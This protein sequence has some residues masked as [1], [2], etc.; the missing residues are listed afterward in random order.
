MVLNWLIVVL[1]K[2]KSKSLQTKFDVCI[3]KDFRVMLGYIPTKIR[4]AWSKHRWGIFGYLAI[5]NIKYYLKKFFSPELFDQKSSID[6]IPGVETNRAVHASSLGYTRDYGQGGS[7]YAAIDENAFIKAL[8]YIPI[9]PSD[10][11][12]VDLGSGKGRALFLAAKAGFG[13]V[14]GVEFSADLHLLA[15]K[16]I[17]A[18]SKS[19]PNTNRIET[20]HGDARSFDPPNAPTVLYLYNPFDAEVMSQVVRN[21]EK[22][23]KTHIHEVWVIYV[24]PV[25]R[26]IFENSPCFQIFSSVSGFVIFKRKFTDVKQ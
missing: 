20:I 11:H 24:N 3:F 25:D 23:V 15:Q 6:Q 1:G 12:F 13:K 14:I 17:V 19:W 2:N 16:N 21:W 5:L 7:A 8:R 26:D 4:N 10:F 9:D 18:A 22:S